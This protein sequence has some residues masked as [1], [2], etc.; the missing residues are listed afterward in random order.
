MS[1]LLI[2]PNWEVR[3]AYDKAYDKAIDIFN[4]V[5]IDRRT[6][7]PLESGIY[8][9][10]LGAT[11]NTD[12]DIRECSCFCGALN[13][14]LYEGEFC[15]E[16]GTVCEEKFGADLDI[17]GWIDLGQ[18]YIIQP[19]A[20]EMIKSVIGA[21]TFEKIINFS[22]LIG[23][24]GNQILPSQL[25]IKQ[26]SPFQ[27]IGLMEFK[28]R[29]VEILNYY[30]KLK[31]NKATKAQLLIKYKARVF[32]SKIPIYSSLLRPAYASGKKKMFSY[33]KINAFYMS[34]INN[35]KL[36]K[37]GSS[38]RLRVGGPL[39][40]LYS[41]QDALQ[42][43]YHCTITSKLSGKKKII[44]NTILSA[45]NCFSARAVITSLTGVNS[46]IDHIVMSY[47]VFL[48]LY[49]LEIL[50]CMMRG[51]GHI[52]FKNMTIYEL[53]QIIKKAKFAYEVD[54]ILYGIM[55]YLI[56][57]H[58][59]GLWVATIRN[60]TMDL[61]SLQVFKIV[62]ILKDTKKNVVQVPMS[63]LD[64]F[65]GDYDGDVLAFFSLKELTVVKDFIKGFNP[66]YLVY[67]RTGNKFYN[68]KMSP[69]KDMNT[70]MTS[71]LNPFI[72]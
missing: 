30:A 18:F 14:R 6:V 47:R 59:Q 11:I 40:T 54:E 19:G 21:K 52:A 27:N 71:F 70:V 43:A 9:P 67:D 10:S 29:F 66:R 17:M 49:T 7:T 28:K 24:E 13:S 69:I 5:G 15:D 25:S 3:W 53:L 38:K 8:D 42:N 16:C 35:V 41:I 64:G 23:I 1:S 36:L 50:N 20:F 56:E 65:T 39:I 12:K 48:E 57:N 68:T 4:E 55:K 22:M 58:K 37:N 60:P 34:I 31:P 2:W 51:L 44:R 33:D 46:G 72:K 61:E 62:D 45:R 26:T 63:S 32:S